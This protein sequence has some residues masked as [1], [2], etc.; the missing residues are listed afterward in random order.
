MSID[1]SA[2][3]CASDCQFAQR[4]DRVPHAFLRLLNLARVAGKFLS[5]CQ[6][7]GVHQVGA[8]NFNDLGKFIRLPIEFLP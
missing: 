4:T 1:A 5:Q 3:G 2:N 6:R 7:R 8:T